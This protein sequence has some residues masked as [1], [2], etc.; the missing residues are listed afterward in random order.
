MVIFFLFRGEFC[1]KFSCFG[2]KL[3]IFLFE[4]LNL[5]F[6]LLSWIWFL[7]WIGFWRWKHTFLK[8][9]LFLISKIPSICSGLIWYTHSKA[10][11]YSKNTQ[12]SQNSQYWRNKNQ[13]YLEV[14][15]QNIQLP[16]AKMSFCCNDLIENKKYYKINFELDR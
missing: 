4:S 11:K 13:G 9:K 3:V 16:I 8:I 6:S 7:D 1:C 5:N 2:S 15:L 10:K 14:I 12:K